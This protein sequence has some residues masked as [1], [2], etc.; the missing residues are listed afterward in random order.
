MNL[1]INIYQFL[2]LSFSSW[3]DGLLFN[4]SVALVP[5]GKPTDICDLWDQLAKSIQ[6]TNGAIGGG[7]LRVASDY[8]Q[9]NPCRPTLPRG[10]ACG[11]SICNSELGEVK[12]FEPKKC[13]HLM[14]LKFQLRIKIFFFDH[15]FYRKLN[16]VMKF[17]EQIHFH[18]HH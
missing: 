3:P 1:S 18:D 11:A 7:P 4:F 2:Q 5:P 9:L 13:L 14:K 10:E 16:I 6:R 15:K 17:M 12:I 8:D